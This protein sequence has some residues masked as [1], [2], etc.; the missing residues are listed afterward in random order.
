[1]WGND[2]TCFIA[3]GV[4]SGVSLECPAAVRLAS[5]RT[6]RPGPVA[7]PAASAVVRSCPFGHEES[8]RHRAHERLAWSL[9]RHR[10]LP[11]DA[12]NGSSA[13]VRSAEQMLASGCADSGGPA[14][15]KRSSIVPHSL[16]GEV[17]SREQRH[18]LGS[19]WASLSAAG[20]AIGPAGQPGAKRQRR[21][22]MTRRSSSAATPASASAI[23]RSAR[24]IALCTETRARSASSANGR[25]VPCSPIE[26]AQLGR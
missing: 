2:G 7:V 18:R 13:L 22:V 17:A 16:R 24:L 11:H 19:L 5:E 25:T 9:R 23:T 20:T 15:A 21:P 1:M 8:S 10:S 3:S 12:R 14:S 4:W 6:V 26:R